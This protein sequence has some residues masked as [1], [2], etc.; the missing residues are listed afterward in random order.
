[1]NERQWREEFPFYPHL[2]DAGVNDA[3]EAL[4]SFR[5]AFIKIAEEAM[6]RIYTDVLPH[7]ETDSWTNVRNVIMDGLLDYRNKGHAQYDFKRLRE[8]WLK[9]HKDEVIA[10]LNQDLLDEVERLKRE[11]HGR[12]G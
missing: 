7:I 11:L 12:W 4:N 9:H 10:D 2:T 8:A 5:G 1:M 6:G 3:E